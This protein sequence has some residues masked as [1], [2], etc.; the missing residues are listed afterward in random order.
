MTHAHAGASP[1][2]HLLVGEMPAPRQLAGRWWEGTG[3]SIAAHA[4]AFA[5]LLYAGSQVPR[6]IASATDSRGTWKI[7]YIDRAGAGGGGGGGGAS[8]DAPRRKPELTPTRP[9]DV[10]P[11]S[12]PADTPTPAVSV[13]IMTAQAM[14]MLPGTWTDVDGTSPGRGTGPGGGNG[15]GPGSGPSRG[16]GAGDGGPEGTG[17]DTF[18]PGNG[19]TAPALLVDV[20][21]AYTVDA[22][23]AKLQG[24]V[25]LDAI[26]LPD[27]T[28]DPRR[29]QITRSL[30]RALGLDDQAVRAVQQWRFRPG[31]LK[32]KPVPVRV[33]VEL[34][35]TLR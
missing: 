9:R 23:R 11:T 4:A 33:H 19:V 28:V 8:T 12:A 31:T 27:G 32:G 10:T 14:Q 21:P 30:D 2:A 29:I 16:S 15:N 18:E 1:N 7:V 13:P 35:F 24:V 20:K 3:L 34:T 6:M 5:I 22:M 17:G 26:V 25:E